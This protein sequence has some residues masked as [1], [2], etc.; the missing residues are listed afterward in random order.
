MPA[1]ALPTPALRRRFRRRLLAWH[2][3]HGRDLPWR[4]TSEPYHFLLSEMVLQQ[5]Q[6][7]RVVPKYHEWLDRYPSLATLRREL[8]E[9]LGVDADVGLLVHRTEHAYPD[10]D[11]ELHFYRCSLKARPCQ[12]WA[13]RCAGYRGKNSGRS[14]F[15]R[16]T[17]N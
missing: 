7:D 8:V 5:T 16:Q 11:V 1:P 3:K 9:E 15:R 2:D 6:V 4:N 10:R 12:C 17:R 13:S 14:A